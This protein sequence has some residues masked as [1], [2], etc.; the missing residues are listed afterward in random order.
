MSLI[1]TRPRRVPPDTAAL[2]LTESTAGIVL[3]GSFPLALVQ[4]GRDGADLILR[5]SDGV[6]VVI[7]GYLPRPYTVSDGNG[8][9]ATATV[10]VTVAE[11]IL[12]TNGPDV[13]DV[14]AQSSLYN[15]EGMRGADTITGGSGNDTISG[16]RHNDTLFG[17]E[18]DDTFLVGVNEGLYVVQGDGAL[19]A[20][21][22]RRTALPL[23]F[24]IS[25]IMWRRF[26]PTVT[27]A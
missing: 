27:R 19:T 23:D 12:G 15:I 3:P 14:S 7:E 18:G 13:I 17:G 16:G 25:S 26:Q 2:N 9:S 24:R 6:T 22:R 11:F 4:F 21:W 8:G 20:C 5:A 10:D 1:P